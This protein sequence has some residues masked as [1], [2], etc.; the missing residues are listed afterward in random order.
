MYGN[1][2]FAPCVK[3]KGRK[4]TDINPDTSKASD[5]SSVLRTLNNATRAKGNDGKTTT[6][7]KCVSVSTENTGG[8]C[9]CTHSKK[10]FACGESEIA[11][12]N[13]TA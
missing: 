2:S 3:P 6:L 1:W 8:L 11:A 4:Q 7:S 5:L 10:G 13:A 9:P 12:N